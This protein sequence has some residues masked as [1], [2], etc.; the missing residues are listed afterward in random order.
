MADW[1]LDRA[2]RLA[3]IN[4]VHDL[5]RTSGDDLSYRDLSA[6]FSFRG[7][8]IHLLGPQGIF[9]PSILDVPLTISTAPRTPGKPPPYDDVWNRDG[10]LE[11]RY[12]G[13][14]PRHPDNAG[15][16]V[17]MQRRLPLVYLHGVT[18]GHY[19]AACPAYVIA[20]DP[21]RL[22][23]KVAV[24]SGLV[25][26]VASADDVAARRKYTARLV[27]QRLHQA[28]FRLRVLAAYRRQC[29]M[30]RLRHAELLD[31][32]HI[33]GD[34]EPLGEPAVSNGLA[35]CKLHHAA[36]D[37]QIVGVRP[38]LVIEVRS[39]VLRERDGPMLRHGLQGLAGQRIWIP[40]KTE[41]QPS[42]PLLEQRFELFKK[43]G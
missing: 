2:V 42:R 27:R 16:V 25:E 17:A 20:A 11:Y 35:L 12:R 30:C 23:F 28:D 14:D 33:V 7:R 37:S 19:V 32:A 40:T 41:E 4:F 21:A 36:F 29:A 5:I 10:S 22:T 6:G 15:L 24:D 39:D 34:T 9:K 8:Q 3:A 13:T 38:D 31:A 18:R 43:A 26:S 1:G